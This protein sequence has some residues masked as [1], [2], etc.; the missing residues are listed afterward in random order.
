MSNLDPKEV[1]SF[2]DLVAKMNS[3]ERGRG[4][5]IKLQSYFGGVKSKRHDFNS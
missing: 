4:N 1:A 5:K 2:A 3:I